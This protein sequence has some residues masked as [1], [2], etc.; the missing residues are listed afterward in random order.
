MYSFYHWRS[1]GSVKQVIWHPVSPGRTPGAGWGRDEC[2]PACCTSSL[3]Q[4]LWGT[5]KAPVWAVSSPALPSWRWWFKTQCACVS[6]YAFVASSST[7]PVLNKSLSP[8]RWA[9]HPYRNRRGGR[10]CWSCN[11]SCARCAALAGCRRW[12]SWRGWWYSG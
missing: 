8:S 10:C 12:Q 5:L 1:C 6:V 2:G 4:A 9:P 11:R 3:S 7:G